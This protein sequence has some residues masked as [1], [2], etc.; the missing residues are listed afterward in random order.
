MLNRR[1]LRIKVMQ[2]LYGFFQ[3]D[4]KDIAKSERELFTGIDKI[5]DLFI[6]QLAFII[7]LRHVATVQME[8]AKTKR[9]PTKEDLDPNL[10]FIS[11]RFIAQLDENIHVKRE[12]NNRKISWNNEFELVRKVFNNIKAS[13]LFG[14][15]MSEAES[16]YEADR[17]FIAEAFR[18]LVADFEL[19]NHFY[20]ERNLHWGDDIY[21]VNPMVL[22]TIESYKEDA[23]PDQALM[24][25]YKDR[26]ED[27]Q[28]VKDLFRQT[29]L[30]NDEIEKLIGDKTKNWEV[31]RIAMMDVLLMKMAIT[32]I[33]HFPSIP[34]KVTLNEFIEISKMYSTP[35]SKI[36]INGILDKIVAD[37]KADDRLN[38]SGRGLME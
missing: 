28:F 34:V 31:E 25:L 4:T 16:S 12:I 33:L 37:L 27:E 15:Y 26:E 19:L 6:Y 3:S 10:R 9:L 18:E 35:K 20:E 30:K 8:E 14:K 13:P 22:K 29:I 24:T 23:Q 21:I 11:N 7:E 36:F 32:E 2:A 38:K 1:Y 17:D 5:Y